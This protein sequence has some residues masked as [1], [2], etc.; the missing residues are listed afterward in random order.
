MNH[1]TDI[2]IHRWAK[3]GPGADGERLRAH[4]AECADCARRYAAAIRQQPISAEEATD[5]RDFVEAGYS[6]ARPK[7][8]WA[9]PA[10]AA[11]LAAMAFAL[12]FLW[13]RNESRPALH[14]R[15][16]AIETF[17]PL[18]W[19]SGVS[20]ARYRVDIYR[21]T[22]RVFSATTTE[23]RL[24]MPKLAPGEYAWTVTA[25][26]AQGREVASSPRRTFT[27]TK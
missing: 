15:G 22:E 16:G 27:I 20:A 2:E 19:A 21:G 18:E 10:I 24:P 6:V 25:L 3:S 4:L 11:A 1:F 9:V 17:A 7:G 14:L 5:V 8:W 26:D 12:P 23:S 13:Q